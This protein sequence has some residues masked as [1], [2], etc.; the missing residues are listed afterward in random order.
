MSYML[1]HARHDQTNGEGDACMGRP[2]HSYSKTHDLGV[3][4]HSMH[5]FISDKGESPDPSK[6][7]LLVI[8]I[9]SV[10]MFVL[11]MM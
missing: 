5:P 9:S 8:Y 11:S 10:Y 6:L 7:L 1:G 3:M 4:P 2:V